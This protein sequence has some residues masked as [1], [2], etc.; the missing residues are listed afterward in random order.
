MNVLQGQ[1]ISLLEALPLT[2]A[3]LQQSEDCLFIN[4]ARPQDQSLKDLP[5]VLWMYVDIASWSLFFAYVLQ[6]WRWL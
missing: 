6:S 3:A 5:V 2:Q 4:V 1:V